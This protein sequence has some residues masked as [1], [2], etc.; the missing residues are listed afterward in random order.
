VPPAN[1]GTVFHRQPIKRSKALAFRVFIG[2][3]I[4]GW[5]QGFLLAIDI[6]AKVEPLPFLSETSEANSNFRFDVMR[7]QPMASA[8]SDQ[9]VKREERG[10]E[11]AVQRGELNSYLNY[12]PISVVLG[13]STPDCSP[14]AYVS[15]THEFLFALHERGISQVPVHIDFNFSFLTPS[16]FAE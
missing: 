11:S 16:E 14:C 7:L 9:L 15:G 13:P 2:I 5:Y 4:F 12:H 1:L 8:L 3:V 6:P 10:L